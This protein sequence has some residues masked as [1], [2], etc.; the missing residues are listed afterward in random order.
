MLTPI[1][2]AGDHSPEFQIGTA[3]AFLSNSSGQ[4]LPASIANFAQMSANLVRYYN[5]GGFTD[6]GQLYQSPTPY[7]VTWW[8]IFNE[9]DINGV[10]AA[11]Y[12]TLYNTVVP[13]MAQADPSIKFV[14]VELAGRAETLPADLRDRRHQLRWMWWPSIFI[15]PADQKTYDQALFSTIPE[16]ASRGPDHVHRDG[17]QPRCWP[18]CPFGSPRTM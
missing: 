2:G 1:Q 11:E 8:G 9:P 7:P 17:H 10:T 3:P 15:P 5:T 12:V 4:I 18:T 14:A 16:F 6:A 13:E